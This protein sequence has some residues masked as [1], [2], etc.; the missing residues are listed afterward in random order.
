MRPLCF[1]SALSFLCASLASPAN[2]QIYSIKDL[3][4]PPQTAY[5]ESMGINESGQVL[6]FAANF[7]GDLPLN[8]PP[9]Y[10]FVYSDG[11]LT[12]LDFDALAIAGDAGKDPWQD[13]ENRKLRITGALT[14]QSGNYAVL[15][16]DHF[17]RTLGALP[18]DTGSVG[19]AVNASGEVAGVSDP[20]EGAEKAFLYKNGNML[21]LGTFPGGAGAEAF[22]S[23]RQGD[24]TGEAFLSNGNGHAF[25]YHKD[26][27][28]DIGTLPGAVQSVGSAINDSLQITGYANSADYSF[29]HAFLWTKG[30]MIDLGVLPGGTESQGDAINS[31]GQVVGISDAA[32]AGDLP[33]HGFV[34]SDGKMRDLN[35]LIPSNSGWVIQEARGINDRGEIATWAYVIQPGKQILHAVVLTLDCKDRRNK[36]C[37]PCRY[38]R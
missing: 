14:T 21:N 12:P 4:I 36:D 13:N 26:K 18:G 5:S 38:G 16:E 1:V 30:K 9:S 32:V 3:G 6:G 7:V 33:I 10:S 15:Y 29:S 2:A 23:N 8:A 24:V 27:M 20:P 25:L 11:R 35:D 37:E 19:F 34:Y 17:L 28:M 31:W 22:G